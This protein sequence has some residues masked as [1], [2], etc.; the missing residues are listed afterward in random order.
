MS[1]AKSAYF[2]YKKPRQNMT[3]YGPQRKV[4]NSTIV[5]WAFRLLGCKSKMPGCTQMVSYDQDLV[6]PSFCRAF[7]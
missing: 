1:I 5:A 2:I 3:G 4:L 7:R 6:G